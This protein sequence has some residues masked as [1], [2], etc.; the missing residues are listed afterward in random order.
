MSSPFDG[1]GAGDDDIARLAARRTGIKWQRTPGAL[2]AWV[3]D[4]DSAPA[5]IIRQRLHEL[6]G[7]GDVG[8]PHWAA[9]HAGSPARQAFMDWAERRWDW[10]IG[11]R[12]ELVELCDVV[13]GIQLALWLCTQPGD[14]VVV[15]TPAYPP[16]LAAIDAVGANRIDLPA[17]RVGEGR[18]E[19]DLEA[20]DAQLVMTPARVLLLCHPHNPT[21]RAFDRAEL[22]ALANLAERHDLVIVSDEIHADLTFGRGHVPMAALGPQVAARTITLHSPSKA[23]NLAGLR[24]AIAHIGPA[25]V[26]D[27]V[28]AL[29]NHLLGAVNLAG[30]VAATA[31]WTEP[32]AARWL[33]EVV[34]HLDGQRH[35]LAALLSEHL[36]QV[37][38]A[39]PEATYLAWLDARALGWGHDPSE[40]WRNPPAGITPVDLSAGPDF[41][42]G[43]AGFVRLNLATSTAMLERI[44]VTMA[45]HH[46]G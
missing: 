20:L 22:Q 1:L 27:R 23:F 24:Y 3:A 26:R 10:T 7:R 30:S 17:Q 9:A 46:T 4:M 8:Y 28:Q 33:D 31:A 34:T 40:R 19:F 43:G 14:G 2:A 13:Q 42:P 21:G 38:Y 5:G 41:G 29:P 36:P 32:A 12:H 37:G 25:W 44:V 15:H 6:I 18:W 39:I 11:D 35:R 45:A 16:M